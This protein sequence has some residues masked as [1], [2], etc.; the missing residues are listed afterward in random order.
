MLEN[1]KEN[2]INLK[3]VF[4]IFIFFIFLI[5]FIIVY[6]K[7][8]GYLIVDESLIFTK[9]YGKWSQISSLNK[10][11]LSKNYSVYSSA[12]KTNNVLLN[13][14]SN[15][16]YYYDKDYTDLSLKK[17][18]VAFTK[19][20]KK[21]KVAKYDFAFYDDNDDSFINEVIGDKSINDFKNSV[22]KS[23]FDLDNDGTIETIYTITNQGLENTKGSFSSIFL[24]KGDSFV[25]MLDSDTKE[26]YLVKNIIDLDGNG[27]YEVIV[28]K[29]TTDV[30]TFDTC[31][32][33]YSISGTKISK[34]K[35]C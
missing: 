32:Q 9:K 34:I 11:I 33:I 26:P 19:E 31:S 6:S 4:G 28:S 12:G 21:L 3:L 15:E 10:D 29:G 7:P 18:Q 23:S 20:F 24:V 13:Y 5:I 2:G 17:V 1:L 27:K 25:G 14:S 30:A 16:W 35:D 8:S 22:I